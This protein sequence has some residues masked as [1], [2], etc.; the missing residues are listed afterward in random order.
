MKICFKDLRQFKE[1]LKNQRVMQE[2]YIINENEYDCH[3]SETNPCR[4]S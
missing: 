2:K 1:E 3:R 4:Y